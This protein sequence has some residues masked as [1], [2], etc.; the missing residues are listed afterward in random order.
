MTINMVTDEGFETNRVIGVDV[1]AIDSAVEFGSCYPVCE[2]DDGGIVIGIVD[3]NYP[4]DLNC[5]VWHIVGDRF[6]VAEY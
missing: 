6:A 4:D 1:D 5:G 2:T 3:A